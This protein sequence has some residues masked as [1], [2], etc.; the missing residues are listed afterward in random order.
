MRIQLLTLAALSITLTVN[1]QK[2]RFDNPP[3]LPAVF[4]PGIINTGLSERDFALSPDETELF[5][6]LQGKP[7]TFQTILHRTKDRKGNW[8]APA[9]APFAGIFS[10]LEPAFSPD[11]NKLF[12]SSNRPLSGSAIKDFDIW[13]VEK[14][15][16]TWGTARNIGSPVNTTADE[17]YPSVSA[18][19]TLY[20]T[21][22]YKTGTGREDIWFSKFE[23]GRYQEVQQMDTAVNSKMYEF[24]AFV[25]PD[26]NYIIF[27]SYGRKDDKGSGDLY[28]SVK[29]AGG[30]WLP[31]KNLSLIN[32][33]KLDY[34]PFLSFDQK[35]LFFTSERSII[36]K[37][38]LDGPVKFEQLLKEFS[39]AQN[40]NGDIYWISFDKVLESIK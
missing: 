25:S 22:T 10:D 6:T 5:Y 4:E 30:K 14:E 8:S 11:G 31:A 17:F 3:P 7:G 24:N 16:G 23:N 38:Y 9:I 26:E 29:D 28:M 39:N 35:K 15:N 21:A 20:F 13:M 2:L 27:T 12:F 40:G 33:E 18:K 34:C 1:S 36:K 19:G 32:S 37:T